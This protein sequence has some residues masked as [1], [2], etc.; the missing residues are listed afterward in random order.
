[1]RLPNLIVVGSI[2]CGTTSLHNYL[3]MHPDI[4]MSKI[5]E[6]EY[7]SENYDKPL[8]WYLNHF[9]QQAKIVGETSPHYTFQKDLNIEKILQRIKS[10]LPNVKIIYIAREPYS[11]LISLY[12]HAVYYWMERRNVKEVCSIEKGNPYL[13]NLLHNRNVNQIL[14]HFSEDKLYTLNVHDLNTNLEFEMNSIF[15]FLNL[16][17]FD[18]PQKTKAFNTFEGRKYLNNFG[19]KID[20][21]PSPFCELRKYLPGFLIKT[22]ETPKLTKRHEA[23]IEAFFEDDWNEY[24][25]VKERFQKT[26]KS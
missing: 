11:Q 3:N 20:L 8:K 4:A 5:K 15:R 18:I 14:E 6:V 9:D 13:Y 7:F 16:D 1:M 23:K 25:K 19:R 17:K 12:K 2:K 10:D 24:L 22:N 26:Y 21:L